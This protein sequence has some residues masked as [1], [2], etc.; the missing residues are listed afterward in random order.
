MGHTRTRG[1][2]P[3]LFPRGDGSALFGRL[4]AIEPR[5]AMNVLYV[6]PPPNR[7]IG[8]IETALND[9]AQA[10]PTHGVHITRSIAADRTQIAAAD[11]VHFHG[12]WEPPHRRSRRWCS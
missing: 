8:G 7:R 4:P 3:Q 9:L 1:L 12:I 5:G 10:L 11:V 6:E 2:R